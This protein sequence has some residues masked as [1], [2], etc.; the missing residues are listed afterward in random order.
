[1]MFGISVLVTACPCALGLATPTAIMVG[2]SVAATSGI[3]VKGADAL[4]RAGALDVVVFDK[5]GTLTT[6]SPTV[7][8]FIASQVET[9]DQ[10]ISLVVCVEKDSEHP[11]AK[12]VRDYARRQSPSEIPSNL[13]STFKTSPAKASVAW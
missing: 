9:L 4:E 2:T 1:M 12:A 7:T 10:I 8:A 3:L 13:K 5:T 6:G 11:I